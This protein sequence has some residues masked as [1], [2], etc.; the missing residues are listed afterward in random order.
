MSC[1]TLQKLFTLSNKHRVWAVIHCRSSIHFLTNTARVWP[2]EL[3][4]TAKLYTCFL[5]N[6]AR[7]WAVIHCRSSIRILTNTGCY[8]SHRDFKI[9]KQDFLWDWRWVQLQIFTQFSNM[10]K[11]AVNEFSLLIFTTENEKYICLVMHWGKNT[12][13]A[14]VL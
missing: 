8:F 14:E 12:S 7:V 6:A 9:H 10:Q 3:L 13:S 11:S 4:Y 1:Y 5:T 2:S